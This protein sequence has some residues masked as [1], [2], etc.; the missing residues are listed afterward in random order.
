MSSI[1]FSSSEL[2]KKGLSDTPGDQK[3]GKFIMGTVVVGVIITVL[4]F[5]LPILLPIVQNIQSIASLL[6]K[7][8]IWGL[9]GLALIVIA[10][11]QTRNLEYFSDYLAR[12]VF[13]GI[14][15]YDPFLIQEKQI[16]QAQHDVEKMMTEKAVIDGKW[17]E[18]NT[19]IGKYQQTFLEHQAGYED[20]QKKYEK[21]ADPEE[22]KIIELAM[23]DSVSTQVSCK[24]YIDTISPIAKDMEYM[25]KF[26]S[27]GYRILTMR[28]KGAKR[29][30]T[31]NKDIFESAQ[32]GGKALERMKRA[33][34][35]DIELNNDAEKAQMEVMK[36]IALTV[37][38]MK[39]SMEIIGNVTREANLEEGSKIAYAR[40]QLEALNL[41]NGAALPEASISANFSKMPTLQQVQVLKVNDSDF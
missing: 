40:K 36:N 20:L 2:I 24:K 9:I 18:L 19:K 41:T 30:L 27:E 23:Q 16:N 15:T 3:V 37:G 22:K 35:G 34:V 21:C 17:T 29:D 38:Q 13:K 33:M 5:L 7:T 25:S 14:I 11:K 8:L 4:Y 28:I 39:V 26:I 6:V 12:L 1:N 10:R 32:A 31:I